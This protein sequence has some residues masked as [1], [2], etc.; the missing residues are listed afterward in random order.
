MTSDE[1]FQL[2]SDKPK[3]RPTRFADDPCRQTTLFHGMD[4]LPGQA[5]LFDDIDRRDET[6]DPS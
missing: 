4:A 3:S 2:S 6:D 1:P 5:D